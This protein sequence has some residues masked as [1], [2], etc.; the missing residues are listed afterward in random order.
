MEYRLT[1]TNTGADGMKS[2]D[3]VVIDP[4]PKDCSLV[5]GSITGEIKN[6][7][8]GS[9]AA[10]KSAE[11]DGRRRTVDIKRPFG[12]RTGYLHSV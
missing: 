2:R 10:V 3:I 4:V 12:R 8:S 9:T 5:E 1:V 7:A 11:N 6:A